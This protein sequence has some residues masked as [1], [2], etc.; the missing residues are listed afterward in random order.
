[1]TRPWPLHDRQGTRDAMLGPTIEFAAREVPFYRRTFGKRRELTSLPFLHKR[2]AIAHQRELLSGPPE[3]FT[4]V[5]SSGTH[6]GE[7]ALLQ[8]PR[9]AD[10]L[11]ATRAFFEAISP[12]GA[13]RRSGW[14]LEVR[15]AHHGT[16]EV[17]AGRLLVPWTYTAQS[18]RL[19][20][21]ML[22]RPQADGRRVDTLVIN[23][24]AL[25][26]L[27]AWF[28]SRG[29]QP[30]RFRVQEIGTT[31][32]KL[33]PFWRERV[34]A[35]W[36]CAVRDNFSLSELPAPAHEC[37]E[38]GFLHWEP[39]P[40]FHEVIDPKSLEPITRGTGVLVVT[41]LAP[42]VTRMPLIR[43]WTGDLV[44]LG[45]RCAAVG[46]EAGLRPRGR[47]A[48]SSWHAEH[49]LLVA[50]IDVNDFLEGQPGVARHAHPMETLGLIPAG[51]CGAVKYELTQRR[52]EV[53][54]KI[55]LRFDPLLF[56]EEAEALRRALAK[57]LRASAPGLR[58]FERAKGALVIDFVRPGTLTSAWVKL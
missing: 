8:V 44:T 53:R 9:T 49:G 35:V 15:A 10:E 21:Q 45:P 12:R 14:T 43:Y 56:E 40:M 47:L 34:E 38:C 16:R 5:I 48:Q 22:A 30:A 26:P 13:A 1:V 25:M 52:R 42:F 6:H 32:F 28:L 31:S 23:S 46:G 3:A 4:G 57:H 33:S 58:A 19:V 51:E 7:G 17:G 50:A 24:G 37:G 36:G 41:T 55:E 11:Q 20:E 54:V 2:D 29:V 18:L 39:P 27:T